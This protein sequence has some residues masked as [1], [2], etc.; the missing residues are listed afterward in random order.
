MNRITEEFKK[1]LVERY[2]FSQQ[3]ES[4]GRTNSTQAYFTNTEEKFMM[5]FE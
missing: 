5:H 3:E 2:H 1:N 4:K